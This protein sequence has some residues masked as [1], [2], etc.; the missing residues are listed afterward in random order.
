MVIEWFSI[1]KYLGLED[2]GDE[3]KR[4]GKRCGIYV[5][6]NHYVISSG[7]GPSP[8]QQ[9]KTARLHPSQTET[10]WTH[11]INPPIVLPISITLHFDA[12]AAVDEEAWGFTGALTAN[13]FSVNRT[14]SWLDLELVCQDPTASTH[15]AGISSTLQLTSSCTM[16][17]N[18]CNANFL[19]HCLIHPC[20][21]SLLHVYLSHECSYWRSVHGFDAVILPSDWTRR[22]SCDRKL[23]L[24]LG[25][26]I[27]KVFDWILWRQRVF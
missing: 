14:I 22:R 12:R 17:C 9:A 5:L 23:S 18:P 4:L 7:L 21:M 3:W 13:R 27:S 26:I 20:C 24:F 8:Y 19:S 15:Q 10:C 11:H 1:S 25:P 2:A 16:D 6:E